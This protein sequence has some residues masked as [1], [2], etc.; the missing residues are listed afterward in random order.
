MRVHRPA[1]APPPSAAAARH[2]APINA[3]VLQQ[4]HLWMA[5]HHGLITAA[6]A[7]ELGLTRKVIE[8]LVKRGTWEVVER[9][10][11]RVAGAPSTPQQPHLAAVWRCGDEAYL[12]GSP[13]LAL[14][15]VQ[16][17]PHDVDPLVL[18]P[19][20]RRVTGVTFDVRRLPKLEPADR[21][22]WDHVPC[23]TPLR[24]LVDLAFDT[25]GRD[26]R[27]AVD[28][29]RRAWK[30]D[31][32]RLRR[33]AV[34]ALPQRGAQYVV[35]LVDS[36][37]LDMES[38]GERRFFGFMEGMT[39]AL[40][41]QQRLLPGLRVDFAWLDARIVV[42][43]D[44]KEHHTL[45]TDREHDRRRRSRLRAEGWMVIV[46]RCADL[47]DPAGL[48]RRLLRRRRERLAALHSE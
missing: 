42:E 34:A 11:Y 3:S 19:S 1:H 36:G 9:G 6:R 8:G 15:G 14:W 31:T 21:T 24:S 27:V 22:T 4:V 45:V 35:D 29:V 43:Y 44:G 5:D 39:P 38:E 30:V 17:F 23:A 25:R 26:F 16:G 48:R 40:A 32:Q 20:G 2:G 33:R 12:T 47:D 7:M 18:I 37:L 10:V 13:A 46:V 28:G 41:V